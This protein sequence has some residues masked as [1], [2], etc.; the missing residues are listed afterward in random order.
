MRAAPV[1]RHRRYRHALIEMPPAIRLPGDAALY[2]RR[3]GTLR[4][5]LGAHHVDHLVPVVRVVDIV[6]IRPEV[7]ALLRVFVAQHAEH[8]R[9]RS[10]IPAAGA[11]RHIVPLLPDLRNKVL[12]IAAAQLIISGKRV[13]LLRVELEW[14]DAWPAGG[15]PWE[16]IEGK[17]EIKLVVLGVVV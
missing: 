10:V 14:P 17:Q 6:V 7:L 12:G 2:R 3:I 13:D 8:M 16:S 4:E 1:G 9:E 5:L 15:V 11:R